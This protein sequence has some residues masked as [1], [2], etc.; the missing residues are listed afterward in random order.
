MATTV[1]NWEMKSN[2]RYW[3]EL[4]WSLENYLKKSFERLLLPYLTILL[5]CLRHC[6]NQ[7]SNLEIY[8]VI[9]CYLRQAG[10]DLPW[11]SQ[12]RVGNTLSNEADA[13]LRQYIG[14]GLTTVSWDH[15]MAITGYSLFVYWYIA[16]RIK[17]IINET[18]ITKNFFVEQ[19]LVCLY[20]WLL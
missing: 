3:S 17:L 15:A 1:I 8:C 14:T 12:F 11:V 6:N 4:L 2:G 10:S 13:A 5:A 19:N 16:L 7:F 18:W 9:S 20:S